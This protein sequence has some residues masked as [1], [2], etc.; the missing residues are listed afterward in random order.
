VA[1]I[2]VRKSEVKSE[3]WRVESG[4][5]KPLAVLHEIVLL[6]TSELL[7]HKGD[8][9]KKGKAKGAIRKQVESRGGA[10]GY[11]APPLDSTYSLLTP[12]KVSLRW[13][14]RGQPLAAP[15]GWTLGF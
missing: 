5:K 15:H 13:A 1:V 3:E 2:G 4:E 6:P 11:T 8:K 7:K 12:T 9:S 10:V 14:R